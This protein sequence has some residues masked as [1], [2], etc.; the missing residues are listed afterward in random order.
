MI[1]R[2]YK[3]GSCEFNAVLQHEQKHIDT[4]IRFQNEYAPKLKLHIQSA[5]R[6]HGRPR[7]LANVNKAFM[8]RDMHKA[9]SASV[10]DYINHMQQAVQRRQMKI[11]SAAEYARVAAQC[12]NW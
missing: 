9:I 5:V 3:S 12:S 10:A 8:Q 1:A 11:D 4:F 7:A 2:N 6:D